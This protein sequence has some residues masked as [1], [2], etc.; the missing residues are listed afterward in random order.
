MKWHVHGT[1][2]GTKYLG[3]FEA[4]TKEE[5]EDMA[6]ES[7]ASGVS[8]CHECSTECED[9]QIDSVEASEAEDA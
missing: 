7:E 1:I 4:D 9:P 5:A 8:L 6:M 2:V 3:I